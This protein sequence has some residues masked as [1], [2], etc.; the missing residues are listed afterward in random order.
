MFGKTG[1]RTQDAGRRLA[2]EGPLAT[3]GQASWEITAGPGL[4]F[5]VSNSR[6][7]LSLLFGVEISVH[8]QSFPIAAL[9]RLNL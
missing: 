3:A 7:R 1:R 6:P 2:Y 9:F 5:I 8:V 4:W